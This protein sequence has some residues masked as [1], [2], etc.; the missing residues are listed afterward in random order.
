MKKEHHGRSEQFIYLFFFAESCLKKRTLN[1]SLSHS[2][3]ED[4]AHG[5]IQKN[6]FKWLLHFK[7]TKAMVKIIFFF[8]QVGYNNLIGP[9]F[10][11]FFWPP[12]CN[13]LL[14]ESSS[15]R[16]L[17]QETRWRDLEPDPSSLKVAIRLL[18]LSK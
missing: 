8:L 17:L 12:K 13:P 3:Y 7:A 1:H 2:L 10:F 16:D 15:Q 18:Q 5:Q 14:A 4:L 9:I 11:F 6:P